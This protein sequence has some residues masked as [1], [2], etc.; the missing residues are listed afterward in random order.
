MM[1]LLF[2]IIMC[3]IMCEYGAIHPGLTDIA[4]DTIQIIIS[5]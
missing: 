4:F 1:L 3:D 5:L 2:I